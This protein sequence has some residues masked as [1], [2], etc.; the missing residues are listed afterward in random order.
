VVAGAGT[1]AHARRRLGR[2][3]Y[4]LHGIPGHIQSWIHGAESTDIRYNIQV[5]AE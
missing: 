2:A 3:L 1:G 5:V 4:P